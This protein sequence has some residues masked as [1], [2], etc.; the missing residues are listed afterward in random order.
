MGRPKKTAL[1]FSLLLFV[2]FLF[3]IT[4][5]SL[6]KTIFVVSALKDEPIDLAMLIVYAISVGTFICFE[7][8]GKWFLLFVVAFWTFIQGSMYFAASF[9]GYYN[10]FA[11]EG[12][13]QIFPANQFFLVKDTYHVVLD[14]LI[15]AA[16]VSLA[17]FIAMSIK[18][19]ERS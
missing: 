8:I 2:W 5:L 6:G 13:H 19:K 7:K 15:L 14:L 9:D 16:F 1:V 10:F 11:N 3:D 17:V 4:G 12:T 18:N